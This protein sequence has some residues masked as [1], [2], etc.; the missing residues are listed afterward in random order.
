LVPPGWEACPAFSYRLSRVIFRAAFF[1]FL[2]TPVSEESINPSFIL[3]LHGLV[4]PESF[5]FWWEGHSPEER[6]H[7]SYLP[8]PKN[9]PPPSFF[10]TRLDLPALIALPFLGLLDSLNC[11]LLYS[12]SPPSNPLSHRYVVLSR[13]WILKGR[14]STNSNGSFPSFRAIFP[15]C[16]VQ[17][18][19][20]RGAFTTNSLCS[21]LFRELRP[22]SFSSHV[23]V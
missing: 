21:R 13:Y 19:P 22:I 11:L 5:S 18:I 23:L 20:A 14:R 8:S 1:Y 6:L 17:H 2:Q 7:R 4:F 12:S 9:T 3:C 15:L 10:G 16:F